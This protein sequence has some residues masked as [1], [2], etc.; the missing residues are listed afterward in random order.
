[1]RT[2][3]DAGHLKQFNRL[4]WIYQGP[5]KDVNAELYLLGKRLDRLPGDKSTNEPL[6]NS[7]LPGSTFSPAT[8]T[9]DLASKIRDDP[10]F[11]I[12]QRKK[13]ALKEIL[14]NP[15][16]LA[17]L[18]RS[19]GLEDTKKKDLK[20]KKSRKIKSA[21]KN[22][23]THVTPEDLTPPHS[24]SNKSATRYSK[25]PFG[26]T[27]RGQDFN[28]KEEATKPIIIKEK[29]KKFIR[30]GPYIPPK[31]SAEEKEKEYESLKRNAEWASEQ[32]EKRIKELERKELKEI[33][34]ETSDIS[35][36]KFLKQVKREAAFEISLKER[37]SRNKYS[38]QRIRNNSESNFIKR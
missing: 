30:R 10:L 13:I 5:N 33:L 31:L 36:A 23:K 8:N 25:L 3:V 17:Q 15:I 6:I 28:E 12:K 22:E 11:L 37:I 9:I 34:R 19:L 26:L 7:E 27:L 14:K 1:M 16:K 21:V 20:S 18:K 29:E 4:D 24:S 2:A 38:N 32:R 35:K